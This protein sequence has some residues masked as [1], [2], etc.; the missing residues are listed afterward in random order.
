MHADWHVKGRKTSYTELLQS[1]GFL[2]RINRQKTGR[3]QLTCSLSISRKLRS[4]INL[5][6]HISGS[7]L[8][9]AS[10]NANQLMGGVDGVVLLG[11][12]WRVMPTRL[13]RMESSISGYFE[14]SLN[15]LG[16]ILI[17]VEI[18]LFCYAL[19]GA[20]R[21]FWLFN[22][23]FELFHF[24]LTLSPVTMFKHAKL[25]HKKSRLI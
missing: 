16:V 23:H 3:N 1:T 9:I 17:W 8:G 11:F 7:V 14:P 22:A 5:R 25:K 6:L 19:V 13:L 12:S 4:S 10:D 2:V 21:F 20:I 18:L 15:R 24:F